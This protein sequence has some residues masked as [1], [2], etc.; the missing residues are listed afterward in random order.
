M[1]RLLA[2]SLGAVACYG[3]ATL[4]P[5]APS[6]LIGTSVGIT[7]SQSVTWSLTG[8][9]TLSGQ[10]ATTVTYNAPASYVP[11]TN[12][13][14]C[15]VWP[16]DEIFNTD[17]SGAPVSSQDATFWASLAGQGIIN[18]NLQFQAA[19]GMSYANNTTPTHLIKPYYGTTDF[20]AQPQPFPA[21]VG[22]ISSGI[23]RREGGNFVGIFGFN[24]NTPNNTADHHSVIINTSNCNHYETYQNYLQGVTQT[25]RDLTTGCTAQSS[26]SF[27]DTNYAA[28]TNGT[29][30]AAGLPISLTWNLHDIKS[31]IH[32]MNRITEPPGGHQNNFVWPATATAGGCSPATPPAGCGPL[33]FL[34]TVLRLKSSIVDATVCNSGITLEDQYCTNIVE[35][36]KHYGFVVADTG[37][38]HA[39]SLFSDAKRDPVAAAAV[40]LVTTNL[41]VNSTNY[42][43]LDL[44]TLQ[45]ANNSWAVCPNG[46]SC[47]T[48]TNTTATPANQAMLTATTTVGSLVTQ[49]PIGIQGVGIGSYDTQYF[50]MAGSYSWQLPF[51]V[52]PSTVS[53][54]VTWTLASGVGSVTSGGVYTPPTTTG[55]GTSA[56]LHGV[57]AADTN[58]SYDIYITVFPAGVNPTGGI[59]IDVGS[60]TDNTDDSGNVWMADK[61]GSE[62][63]WDTYSLDNPNWLG[64]FPGPEWFI[65]QSNGYGQHDMSYSFV[66]PNGNYKVRIGQAAPYKGCGNPEGN[67]VF[68]CGSYS[69]L[70]G[71]GYN[72]SVIDINGQYCYHNWFT[73]IPE[74]NGVLLPADTFC[75][76]KVNGA[77]GGDVLRIYMRPIAN[78]IAPFYSG[79]PAVLPAGFGGKIEQVNLLQV[80][81]DATAAH[82]AVD[83]EQQTQISSGQTLG[84]MYAVD[85]YTGD[86]D[87]TTPT[88]SIVSGVPGASINASTGVL[89]LASS[90]VPL[91]NQPIIVKAAGASHSATATIFT[92]GTKF[93]I[94]PKPL[95]NH[96][97]FK[98][99]LTLAHTKV[100]NTDQTNF[101]V[102]VSI[103]DPTLATAAHGGN[104]LNAN[105]FDLVITS[106]PN[107]TTI[108]PFETELYNPTTGQWIAWYKQASL[109]HTTDTVAYVCYNN[110][111]IA[112]TQANPTA[113]WDTN[114][115]GVYHFAAVGSTTADSTT[116]ANT[117]TVG[118]FTTGV[119]TG[120]VGPGV[121][122]GSNTSQVSVSN[123][124]FANPAGTIEGWMNTA[125]VQA[126]NTYSIG[127]ENDGSNF[128][129][130]NVNYLPFPNAVVWG[131]GPASGDT[132]INEPFSTYT[133][134]ANVWHHFVYTWDTAGPTQKVFLDGAQ[135]G[136]TFTSAI[137]TYTP[138]NPF[139]IG[140]AS[141]C[142]LN[143]ATLDEFEFSKVAR[144]NDWIATQYNNQFS[145]STFETLGSQTPN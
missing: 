101:P 133:V 39:P 126:S 109:S 34:G 22:P 102:L 116:N 68:P 1:R 107:C 4:T 135:V 73:Q 44:S 143:P 62:V 89:T 88:W 82:W 128:F 71:M 28:P 7:A 26:F 18:D 125:T 36:M 85:W 77:S 114:Y 17:I 141:G 119:S 80:I 15:E 122:F 95:I 115:T 140:C 94:N 57:A 40:A 53:Q 23:L 91:A 111:A 50:V 60:L 59:R 25:C 6:A 13:L 108:I 123:A 42:E 20:L 121:A 33:P 43:W 110:N 145:P 93:A 136:S 84:P 49:V 90:P 67:R 55:G 56:V 86:S 79:D 132:R 134:S 54:S 92:T 2:I 120:Q 61:I 24:L 5:S 48:G 100:P 87:I 46:A 35:G 118:V 14:G 37:S 31:G 105:G 131:W 72:P 52:T 32:H 63:P 70:T 137:T 139:S 58:V 47:V 38:T 127:L 138:T 64:Q 113:V 130:F 9:G 99:T 76:G 97:N 74:G 142:N 10:T 45:F 96:F 81:P 144:S 104:V 8:P 21:Q 66:V 11:K 106:D 29:T 3:Q 27:T 41:V 12:Q 98:R 16:N 75:P 78:D 103:T 83:T 19:W 69:E 65:Y 124:V 51:W 112:G 129:S 117:G 30:D